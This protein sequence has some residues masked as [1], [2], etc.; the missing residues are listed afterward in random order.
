MY[1]L[2]FSKRYF[3]NFL[4]HLKHNSSKLEAKLKELNSFEEEEL[5]TGLAQVYFDV[6]CL[7]SIILRFTMETW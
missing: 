2:T 4:N 5:I 6:F 7:N 1:F 3:L